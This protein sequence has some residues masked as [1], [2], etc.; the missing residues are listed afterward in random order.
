MLVPPPTFVTER[1][2]LRPPVLTDAAAIFRNYAQDPQVTRFL[3]WRPHT[4][5]TETEAFLRFCLNEWEKGTEFNWVMT[6]R[7]ADEAIGMI[8]V[9]PEDFKAELGY[10]LAR[11]YWGKGLVTEAARAVGEW[12]R[13]VPGLYRFWATCD[14]E[15]RASARVM[16]KIGMERE[17]VL[18]RHMIRPNLSPEPRDT[19]MYAWAR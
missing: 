5:V 15:H 12:V 11:A 3:L 10:V 6:L 13:S 8:G 16:E 9:R 2:V 4:D 14:V 1:L 7:G 19:L 17:G 18:R